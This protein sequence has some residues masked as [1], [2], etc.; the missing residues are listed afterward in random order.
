M[1]IKAIHISQTGVENIVTMELEH[2]MKAVKVQP[3]RW[4]PGNE[5]SAKII[6]TIPL[7]AVPI[8]TTQK[9][10]DEFENNRGKITSKGKS[11]FETLLKAAEAGADITKVNEEHFVKGIDQD[12]AEKDITFEVEQVKT[13]YVES[14]AVKE[15]KYSKDELMKYPIDKIQAIA[16]LEI[17]DPKA[18]KQALK[19]KKKEEIVNSILSF[20]N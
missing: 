6:N 3:E 19:S 9:D 10:V 16:E 18:L 4:K 12:A 8:G 2:Y 11:T 5:E 17:T 20:C 1:K 13:D 7:D 14:N 15:S